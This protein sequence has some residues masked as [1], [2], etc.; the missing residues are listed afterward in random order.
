MRPPT[1]SLNRV[2]L[3]GTLAGNPE[4][5]TE[6]NGTRKAAFTLTTFGGGND[7]ARASHEA[8]ELH[9]CVAWDSKG[10]LLARAVACMVQ[11]GVRQLYVIG[12]L[13]YRPPRT[14]GRIVVEQVV[15]VDV[16][17]EGE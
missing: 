1:R 4:F 7:G 12:R 17:T 9:R 3:L 11:G 2:C 14:F 5:T 10:R 16:A 13:D 6:P 8:G 15:S